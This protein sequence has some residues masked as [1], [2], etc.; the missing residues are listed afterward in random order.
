[1][2]D[3]LSRINLSS[4]S[5]F[6]FELAKKSIKP[7]TPMAYGIS[8]GEEVERV[9]PIK[10]ELA[11]ATDPTFFNGIGLYVGTTLSSNP[12]IV[13]ANEKEQRIMDGFARRIRLFRLII[14]KIIQNLCVYG[15]AWNEIVYARNGREDDLAHRE[16][17]NLPT[18][19]PKYMDFLRDN[20]TRKIVFNESGEP[21]S[22]VQYLEY[23]VEKRP[24]EIMQFGKRAVKF[25]KERVMHT[26][27]FTLGDS[28]DGV[29][30]IEPSYNDFLGKNNARKGLVN[31]IYRLGFPLIGIK[32]GNEEIFPTEE[33]LKKAHNGFKGVN[34]KSIISHPH[35][36]EPHIIE[37]KRTDK[38]QGNLDYFIDAEIT[39]IGAPR[40]LVTGSGE[41]TN[42]STLEKQMML[43]Y[44][45][46]RWIQNKVSI[47]ME[48]QVFEKIAI[49]KGFDDVPRLEWGEVSMESLSG[50]ADR[51]V[52]YID[53][54]V[55]TPDE[56]I[57]E[58][59][60]KS[61]RLPPL[62]KE[63]IKQVVS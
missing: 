54:G 5:H 37:A 30:L 11:Y 25:P 55:L 63:K 2:F 24:N 26:T 31:S 61:E 59:V 45:R 33:M 41:R 50:K 44:Q 10:L 38:M 16:I 42:R 19:D 8:T 15:N 22:Y 62:D 36:V 18:R 58:I 35:Y 56:N 3:A 47:S 14:P 57:E 51:L 34:E 49:Q 23:Y 60:R 1:M 48:D 40:P 53:A 9:S 4:A 52:K 28:P 46:I 20:I 29:G 43:F 21:E 27:L 6:I 7:V 13:C 12:H 39:S 17:M 32:V